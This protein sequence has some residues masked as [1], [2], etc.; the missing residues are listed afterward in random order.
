MQNI[1]DL[2]TYADIDPC[3][4]EQLKKITDP[5]FE[6][7]QYLNSFTNPYIYSTILC[8]KVKKIME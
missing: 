1:Q 3:K 8:W 2:L 5:P 4:K 6:V 7:T